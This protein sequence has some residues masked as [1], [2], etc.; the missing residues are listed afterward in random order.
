[1]KK[2][3]SCLGICFFSLFAG[4]VLVACSQPTSY[5]ISLGQVDE[6]VLI[7]LENMP[8]EEILQ[9]NEN[10]S[11]VVGKDAQI[12]VKVIAKKRGVDMENAVIRVNG[13]AKAVD[14]RAYDMFDEEKL[15]YCFFALPM[16]QIKNNVEISVTGTAMKKSTFTFNIA[17]DFT[18]DEQLSKKLQETYI[19]TDDSDS[20]IQLY[21]LLLGNKR[22]YT[23]EFNDEQLYIN[24]Y[25][26][27]KIQF[28]RDDKIIND[29][30][31]CSNANIFMITTP[32][33]SAA[34]KDILPDDDHL[35][36]DLGKLSGEDNYTINVNFGA[37]SLAHYKFSYP[38]IYQDIYE[39]SIDKESVTYEEGATLT[40]TKKNKESYDYSKLELKIGDV[41]LVANESLA[42]DVI[43]FTI[44]QH[45]TP[46]LAGLT[47]YD[48]RRQLTITVNGITQ[49]EAE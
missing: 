22:S 29:L 32:Q 48:A 37:L 13:Q 7:Q 25:T 33:T 38:V 42:E 45:L 15:T 20:Y 1:M 49:K 19:C 9:P 17:G 18:S 24:P 30:Y 39:I 28:R 16:T 34:A 5:T 3:L 46:S 47:I 27:F 40:F 26:T 8:E 10:N 4:I 44:P 35:V 31:D 43:T 36:V 12:R 11:W 41:T 14:T 21:Q 2:L 23:R 6:N